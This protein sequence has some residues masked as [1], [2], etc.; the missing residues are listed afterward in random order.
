MIIATARTKT[1]KRWKNAE[2]TWPQF[3]DRLR[4][5]TRTAESVKEYKNA[6]KD[7]RDRIKDTAGGF[8]GGRLDGPRRLTSAVR[9]RYLLTLDADSANVDSLDEGLMALCGYRLAVYS[10]HS[11]T[12][13]NPRL[14]WIVPTDRPMTCEEYP[15]VARRV[16]NWIGID[17]MDPTT[18]ETARLMYWPT[19]A[20]DGEYVCRIEEGEVLRVDD[21]LADYGPE[22]TWKDVALWPV[23]KSENE[24]RVQ[25][26]KRAGDPRSKQGVVGIFCRCYD[27]ES[28]IAEFLPDVYE[29]AGPGRYTYCGGSTHG[30]AVIYNDG[31]FL[32]SNHA[33]DPCAG[34]STNAFDL[35]RIHKF[36][37]LDDD[38]QE[39]GGITKSKSYKAMIDWVRD[40]PEVKQAIVDETASVF[41]DLVAQDEAEEKSNGDPNWAEGL[42]VDKSGRIESTRANALLI[43]RND[44]NLKGL[45]RYSDF[46]YRRCIYGSTTPWRRVGVAEDGEESD[47]TDT[48]S[49]GI[50]VYLERVWGLQGRD[51]INDALM[52]AEAEYHY[53]PVCEYLDSLVWDGKPRLDDLLI[54]YF[55]APDNDYDR[56]VTRRFFVGAVKRVH[57]PGC[58]FDSV[59]TLVSPIQGTGK[60]QFF[61]IL[62]GKWFKDGLAKV[63]QKDTLQSIRGVWIVE[64]A[65]MSATRRSDDEAIKQFFSAR[66]DTYRDSYAQY[67][68]RY[69]RQCVFVGTT[70]D[71]SFIT[72]QTGGRRFWPVD[73][74]AS[75][76][77]LSKRLVDLPAEKD[78]IWAEAMWRYRNGEPVWLVENELQAESRRVQSSYTQGDEWVGM[79]EEFLDR[80]LPD[81][82]DSMNA[83]QRIDYMQGRDLTTPEQRAGY[84]RLRDVVCVAE[85]RAE[86]LGEDV[87]RGAGGNNESSRHLGKIMNNNLEW[88]PVGA[89]RTVYGMQK[90]YRRIT[91]QTREAEALAAANK[92]AA[93]AAVQR[94]RDSREAV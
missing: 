4:I 54:R 51:V 19:V 40:L 76:E 7:E 55:D 14:R 94:Y 79:V 77:T 50:R 28:A 34:R 80:P 24:A 36:G 38:E 2:L 87:R 20:R 70:N 68:Q 69:P 25:S 30:G 81:A 60:S 29:E 6:S 75:W 23:A 58:K 71:R 13:E 16:A 53:H 5:P 3:C 44:P 22:D 37:H 52:Q 61:D 86:L 73:C 39:D 27:V 21:V 78:Q 82:W 67:A 12:P 47:W 48:D 35:V 56:I 31:D 32:F 66:V 46:T 65:E 43:L 8:V 64:V 93:E 1:S 88:E 41:E 83:D 18:Y 72:D 90:C 59:L 45:V 92:A 26:V 9:E 15:A 49:A 84:T 33:T 85:L 11:H 17:S 74:R 89:R 10:T 42:S 62:A 63:D 57:E 91:A